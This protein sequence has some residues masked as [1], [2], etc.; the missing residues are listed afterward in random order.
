MY[1]GLE[2]CSNQQ[3]NFQYLFCAVSQIITNFS[4]LSNY[5]STKC[6]LRNIEMLCLKCVR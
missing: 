4:V 1:L 2:D 5:T 3:Y 6:Y